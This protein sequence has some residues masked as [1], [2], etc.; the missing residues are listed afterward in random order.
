MAGINDPASVR[1]ARHPVA[2]RWFVL[3]TIRQHP[4]IYVL[5]ARVSCLMLRLR[6][7]TVLLVGGSTRFNSE[8][9]AIFDSNQVARRRWRHSAKDFVS[10]HHQIS[11]HS[12][13]TEGSHGVLAETDIGQSLGLRSFPSGC[14]L[15]AHACAVAVLRGLGFEDCWTT[16]ALS[17][18]I[19]TGRFGRLYRR[20]RRQGSA[21]KV[22]DSIS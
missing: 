18:A 16:R 9:P 13:F 19:R 4:R 22:S 21:L 20:G 1:P 12:Q 14:P 15:P 3:D 8:K 17:L 10:T 5:F 6:P 2:P 7:R 11:G